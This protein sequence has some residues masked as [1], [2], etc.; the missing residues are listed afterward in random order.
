[1][2][3]E[4]KEDRWAIII[5]GIAVPGFF[6]EA[7]ADQYII[8]HDLQKKGAIATTLFEKEENSYSVFNG[9]GLA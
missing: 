9:R 8:D 7:E 4:K 5:D 2:S 6:S 3:E 1:M